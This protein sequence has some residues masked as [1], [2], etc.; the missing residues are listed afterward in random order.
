MADTIASKLGKT[1]LC[2]HPCFLTEAELADVRIDFQASQSTNRFSRAGVGQ[3]EHRELVPS[4]RTDQTLWL[5][6]SHPT[7][8]EA[9]LLAKFAELQMSFNRNLYLGITE[10]E[11]HYARYTKGG[12]YKRHRDAFADP[13]R[14]SHSHERIVSVVLYLNMSWQPSDGGRLRIYHGDEHIDIDP[15]GGT[16]VCFTSRDTEHEVLPSLAA[17]E[18]FAGW[19][20]RSET[21]FAGS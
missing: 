2:V 9:M 8:A 21:Y 16:L 17:R 11:G 14:S 3:G 6:A 15:I 19:Y 10:F 7:R 12:F 18:S 13:N 4:V 1:G 5:D 20:S